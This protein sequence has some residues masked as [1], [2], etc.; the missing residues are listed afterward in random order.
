M[1]DLDKVNILGPNLIPFSVWR[2][3]A[4]PKIEKHKKVKNLISLRNG[5]KC[6][7]NREISSWAVL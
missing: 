4:A 2:L 1:F 6:Y 5:K 3:D 7:V